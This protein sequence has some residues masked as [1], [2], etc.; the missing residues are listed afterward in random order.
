MDWPLLAVL[1]DEERRSL[2]GRARRRRFRRGEVVFHEGDPGDALHLV[3]KGHLIVQRSTPLGDVATLLVLGPGDVF[4]ELAVV[5]PAPR[6]ATVA[7]LDPAETL[8][9]HRDVFDELR[10]RHPGLDRMLVNSLA[11]EVRRLSGLLVEAHYVAAE[12]RV[13]L[14]LLDL[15]RCFG[16]PGE[17]AAVSIPLTQEQVGHMAGTT[18]PT[19]NR[20]LRAAEE[21]GIVRMA[22]GH[23][24]VLNRDGLA[25][26]A[27]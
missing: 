14:R 2:L 6:N 10:A 21:A 25:R 12:K 4:G 23:I 26:R 8:S 27:R 9:V 24:E 17:G 5:D 19:T 13:Y 16:G 3:D 15:A 1:S 18:R 11:A 7:A 20:V 22:R